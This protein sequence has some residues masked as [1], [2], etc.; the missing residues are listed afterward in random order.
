MRQNSGHYSFYTKRV[1]P[2]VTNWVNNTGSKMYFNPLIPMRKLQLPNDQRRFKY[3]VIS[4]DNAVHDLTN[5]S[6]FAFAGR[7]QK[8]VLPFINDNKNVENAIKVNRNQALNMAILMNYHKL[9]LDMMEL[10]TT[11]CQLSYKGDIRMSFKMENP[12]KVKNIVIGSYD[13]L[14]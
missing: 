9:E 12:N 13:G 11:I 5:W 6:T 7:L 4:V 10:A 8:P 14:T 2:S 3:G 1:P